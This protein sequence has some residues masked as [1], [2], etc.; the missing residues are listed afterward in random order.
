MLSEFLRHP[1]SLLEYVVVAC[2]RQMLRRLVDDLSIPYMC[3]L[4]DIASTA[5]SSIRSFPQFEN[6]TTPGLL[7]AK[8]LQ[9]DKRFFTILPLLHPNLCSKIPRLQAL[10]KSKGEASNDPDP[11]VAYYNKDTYLEYHQLLWEIITG[12][13]I[14]LKDLSEKQNTHDEGFDDSV[15]SVIV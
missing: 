14:S 15:R 10:S 7:K 11:I 2:H 9:S 1:D 3:F 6:I 5:S 12:F 13:K 8:H 4:E